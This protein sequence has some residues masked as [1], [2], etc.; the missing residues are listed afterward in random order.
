M[1]SEIFRLGKE[2]F[3]YMIKR[4][5]LKVGHSA[6]TWP[7]NEV[8]NA[9]AAISRLGFHG[10]EVFGWVLESLKL[11]NRLDLFEKYSLP[12]ISSYFSLDIINP[13]A[14]ETELKKLSS[15][16]KILKDKGGKW[17]TLGGN[18]IERR[19][20]NFSEHKNYIVSF[21]N[22]AGR[23]LSDMGLVL[24]FHPHTGTPIENEHEIKDFMNSVDIRY[25]GFTP[26]IGQIQKGGTDPV[27]IIKEYLPLIKLVHLKD[28]SGEVRCDE[29]G[30]EIDTSGFCCYSPLGCGVV[31]LHSVL[32]ILEDSL[33]DGYIIAELDRGEN[34]PIS[35]EEA[36]A[37][38]MKYLREMNYEFLT[39]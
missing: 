20:Y 27:K 6:I 39:K 15:W 18:L 7:D 36:V 11:Q 16:G 13:K 1:V 34:M 12:L 4:K 38:N 8:E 26:D 30:K 2:G 24:G 17:V 28:F 5:R 32:E 14:K 3:V 35:P 23:I 37:I 33:F 9:I 21:V 25:V 10:I 19:H 29:N 31:D 22:E